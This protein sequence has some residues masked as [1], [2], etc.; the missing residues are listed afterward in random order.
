MLKS[1]LHAKDIGS[2]QGYGIM[3]KLANTKEHYST[4]FLPLGGRTTGLTGLTGRPPNKET[5][6]YAI[7]IIDKFKFV[8]FNI[9]L[10]H[11]SFKQCTNVF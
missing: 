8:K 3:F 11:D 9:I 5:N 10:I 7:L 4:F 1:T 6:R 2:R